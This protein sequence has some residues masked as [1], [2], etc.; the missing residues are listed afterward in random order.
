M[1]RLYPRRFSATAA[2]TESRERE[3][4]EGGGTESAVS[5]FTLTRTLAR[6]E[7]GISKKSCQIVLGPVCHESGWLPRC[8]R[9]SS[10]IG[11]GAQR[12][13]NLDTALSKMYLR[14]L[15]QVLRTWYHGMGRDGECECDRH[16]AATFRASRVPAGAPLGERQHLT[17]FKETLRTYLGA[18]GPVNTSK[19]FLSNLLC[20][21][22]L[23]PP[24][25][26]SSSTR[27]TPK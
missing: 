26:S 2:S 20:M 22:S 14:E 18:L 16:L 27:T 4:K 24:A 5:H 12:S 3:R 21:T 17:N 11:T 7:V 9:M 13:V 8:P 23:A 25:P 19:I 1:L 6:L 10:T 15:V